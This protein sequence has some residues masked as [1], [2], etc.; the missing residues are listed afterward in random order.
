[1][2]AFF[3][4]RDWGTL[5][6]AMLTPFNSD[7]SVNYDEA[8]RLAVFLVDQQNNDGLVIA[9]TTGES[10]TLSE[11]EK[12]KLLEVALEAVGDRAAIVFGAGS[13]NTAESIHMTREAEKRGAHGIMLVNPYYN[14]PG[15]QGLYA[16]FSTIARE[17]GLPVLLYNIFPRSAINLETTTLLRLAEIPNIVAVKEASGSLPQISEV[18]A[19]APD[20]FRVYSGD[21][22]LTL[23][24]LSVGGH[25]LVSV[26]A[27][28]VGAELKEM[29]QVFGKNPARAL[30]LHQKLAP[31]VKSLFTAPSP[32]PVK[33]AT[34]LEGFKCKDVRLPLVPLTEAE[35]AGVLQALAEFGKRSAFLDSPVHA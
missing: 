22:G 6:T 30:E 35:E 7:G 32:V 1:M 26:A 31:V 8:A 20:G 25:G 19:S 17:T 11:D 12:L 27:H 5:L 24:I 16:H 28:V 18:A 33:Y 23:P 13:Y 29:I 4:P 14:R 21:D 34:S 15:Q 3:G 10:P 9:G 2:G